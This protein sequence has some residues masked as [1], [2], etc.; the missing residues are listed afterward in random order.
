MVEAPA[1]VVVQLH[2]RP[3]VLLRNDDRGSDVG[4][5]DRL[6]LARHLGRV[7]HLDDLARRR[8]H[9]VGDVRRGHEQVEVELALQALAH[10]LHVQEAEE[11]AAEAEAERL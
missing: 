4:L 9:L 6:E 7:V 11:P 10:D 2:H 1:A 8:L 5:L 3:D